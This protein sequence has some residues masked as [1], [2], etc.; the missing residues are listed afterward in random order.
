LYFI[1]FFHHHY[2]QHASLEQAFYQKG[3]E[4]SET[5]E[6]HLN[7][8]KNYFFS[9]EHLPRTRKH[10]SSPS[11]G[12]ACKRLVMFL[13]W[14]VRKGPVDFGLWKKINTHQLVCPCDVHVERVARSMGL[15]QR[16]KVDWQ[17]AVA[18]T[19]QL[20]I[21]DANDPVKYDFA[22]FGSGVMEG[23]M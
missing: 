7:Y 4:Q 17:T 15:I 10:I 20:K 1:Q 11:T 13:R 5:V 9:L 23:G 12:A 19:Q 2:S 8:F 3:F 18:L 21:Y 6:M 14:M 22:L 16:P